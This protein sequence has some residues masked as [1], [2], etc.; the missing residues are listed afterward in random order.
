MPVKV[1]GNK[2]H[3]KHSPGLAY[4]YFREHACILDPYSLCKEHTM[5]YCTIPA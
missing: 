1:K 4:R 2:Y 5:E 3:Y